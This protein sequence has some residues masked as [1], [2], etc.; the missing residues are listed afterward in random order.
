MANSGVAGYFGGGRQS[1]A[2]RAQ[3]YKLTFSSDTFS[4]ITALSGVGGDVGAMANSGVAG[5]FGGGQTSTIV[6][7]YII[8]ADTRSTLGT[9]LS[10]GRNRTM[11]SAHSGVAGYFG[12]GNTTSSVYL[13]VVDKF[14]FPSDTRTTLATGLATA[15]TDHSSMAN[16]GTL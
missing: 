4:T 5:Y 12:G 16:S 13:S 8:P 11:G 3:V 10:T 9:G 15:R 1:G 2:Q 7:K 14:A 6:D